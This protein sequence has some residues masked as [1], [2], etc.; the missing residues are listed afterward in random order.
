MPPGRHVPPLPP[1]SRT[2]DFRRPWAMKPDL[3]AFCH[4]CYSP[5]SWDHHSPPNPSL[6]VISGFLEPSPK[7]NVFGCRL[8]YLE[9]GPLVFPSLSTILLQGWFVVVFLA[10]FTNSSKLSL[11]ERCFLQVSHSAFMA[12]IIEIPLGYAGARLCASHFYVRLIKCIYFPM[13]KLSWFQSYQGWNTIALVIPYVWCLTSC[14]SVFLQDLSL[15]Q[16]G[17][18]AFLFSCSFLPFLAFSCCFSLL[19]FPSPVYT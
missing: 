3:V 18:F 1:C 4:F 5:P 2:P 10:I 16:R 19:L 15:P 13:T 9:N 6:R 11:R 8:L 17:T 7:R 12:Q 14:F